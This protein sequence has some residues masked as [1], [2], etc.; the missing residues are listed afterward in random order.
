LKVAL[1][2][3]W[4]AAYAG[5]ERV[6]EQVL[7]VFPQAD[8]FAVTDFLSMNERAFL[9]G[10]TVK[11]TFIQR[12]PFARRMFRAYLPLM[13]IA[14]EQL[15]MRG[16]DLVISSS[17]AVA[18]GV[19]TGPDQLH[20]SYVHSPIRYAWDLQHQYLTESRLNGVRGVFAR[21]ILHYIRMWDVRTAA[22]VDVFLTNSA[23]IGRRVRKAYR[24]DSIVLPPP[25]DIGAFTFRREKGD[26]Y[27]AVARMVPYKKMPVIIEAFARMPDK[28][29]VVV[30]EGPDFDRCRKLATPNIELV[31]CMPFEKLRNYMQDARA[32]VFAAE[33]DFGIT[34]VEVQACGTP[35]IAF[36]RG[37]ARE[38]VRPLGSSPMPTGV[39]F[40]EQLPESIVNAVARF[41]RAGDQICPHACRDNAERFSLDRFRTSLKRLVDEAFRARELLSPAEDTMGQKGNVHPETAPLAVLKY[42]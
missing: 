28:R 7:Q 13:P 1:V 15:D 25:V 19:I 26:Y 35:V 17:H 16:Y 29:L 40:D 33:E 30:G 39:F 42:P 5:S 31:G 24:R 23:Y 8:V 12:L 2:H 34:L 36:G 14:I 20:I 37:G 27:L 11:T 3:E 22:G 18:K 9:G 21:L 4:F 32:F 10:R 41:E 38:I 6:V